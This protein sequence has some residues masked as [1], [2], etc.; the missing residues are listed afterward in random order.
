MVCLRAEALSSIAVFVLWNG[1]FLLRLFV[2]RT[3]VISRHLTIV[4]DGNEF[5]SPMVEALAIYVTLLV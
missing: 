2:D 4:I 5:L 1:S 3:Q